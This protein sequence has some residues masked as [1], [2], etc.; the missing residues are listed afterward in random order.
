MSAEID[1]QA[2]VR[3]IQDKTGEKQGD[4]ARRF[5]V[6]Q[7]TVSRWLNGSPPELHHAKVIEQ[8]ARDLRVV[9]R[10]GRRQ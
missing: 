7:P 5:G 4:L 9:N 3:T 6:S 2:I 1:Y 8:V 10:G